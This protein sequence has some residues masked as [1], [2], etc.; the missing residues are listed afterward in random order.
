[1]PRSRSAYETRYAPVRGSS[2]SDSKKV[3]SR[4]GAS[5]QPAARTMVNRAFPMN[6]RMERASKQAPRRAPG[7]RGSHRER[8]GRPVAQVGHCS[9]KESARAHASRTSLGCRGQWPADNQGR[10]VAAAQ[11]QP[12]PGWR[13]LRPWRSLFRGP[14]E[15]YP[16]T[17]MCSPRPARCSV[18]SRVTGGVAPQRSASASTAA[19]R[20]TARTTCTTTIWA[21]ARPGVGAGTVAPVATAGAGAVVARASPGSGGVGARSGAR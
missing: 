8:R 12:R 19:Q 14:V 18:I 2:P 9:E 15:T 1:M 16:F 6:L 20:I 10:A 21:C 4:T 13:P 7:R 5:P 11:R 17:R 3:S